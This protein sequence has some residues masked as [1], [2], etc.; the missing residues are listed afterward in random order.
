MTPNV[1]RQNQVNQLIND[2]GIFFAFSIDSA[3]Q[4]KARISTYCK[5]FNSTR[6]AYRASQ[7]IIAKFIA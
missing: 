4:K 1:I 7:G 6:K 3:I 2:I 5:P